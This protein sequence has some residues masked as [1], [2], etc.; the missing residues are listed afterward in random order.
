MSDTA[1]SATFDLVYVA[2]TVPPVAPTFEAKQHRVVRANRTLL[3]FF[4]VV[5]V[6]GIALSTFFE[7]S[8]VWVVAVYPFAMLVVFP[9]ARKDLVGLFKSV[10]VRTP[11]PVLR[12]M[13]AGV[14]TAVAAVCIRE[15]LFRLV[16]IDISLI[17]GNLP[18]VKTTLTETIL[19]G[20]GL[21]VVG[22]LCEE[23]IF[24]GVLLRS[25]EGLLSQRAAWL[26]VSLLFLLIHVSVFQM[27]ALVPLALIVTRLV[28]RNAN[29]W[30]G[31]IMHATHN[32]LVVFVLS[33]V[34]LPGGWVAML[35]SLALVGV[36]VNVVLRR[37]KVAQ[38]TLS[39]RSVWSGSLVTLVTLC[40]SVAGLGLI[41]V[42]YYALAG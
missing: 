42:A 19:I 1:G 21:V 35:A 16:G 40:G 30:S 11:P 38:Q 22:P 39:L 3:L 4:L 23:I 15:V 33:Q 8:F 32:A 31:F 12:S 41:G 13:G 29:L 17:M 5:N 9:I 10:Y 27:L 24:R 36:A 2:P 7:D 14:L 18:E 20:L 34:A 6:A 28:Q 26:S 25:Y 37:L